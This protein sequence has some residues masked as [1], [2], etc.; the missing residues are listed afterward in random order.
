MES[1]GTPLSS[2]GRI[3]GLSVIYCVST[4]VA[5]LVKANCVTFGRQ[6]RTPRGYTKAIVRWSVVAM[7]VFAVL[8]GALTHWWPFWPAGRRHRDYVI[9]LTSP[10]AK[11]FAAALINAVT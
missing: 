3:R 4:S 5:C 7:V 2:T 9:V 1:C 11:F 6:R 8:G 10:R